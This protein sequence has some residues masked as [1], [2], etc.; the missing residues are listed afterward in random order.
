MNSA[1]A[2]EVLVRVGDEVLRDRP[3]VANRTE[4]FEEARVEELLDRYRFTAGQLHIA[5]LNPPSHFWRDLRASERLR[6]CVLQG[7]RELF[8]PADFFMES[9]CAEDCLF[10]SCDTLIRSPSV[11]LIR[12]SWLWLTCVISALDERD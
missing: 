2:L 7:R 10:F 3:L 9:P 1:L 4:E 5:S 11:E 6:D 8:A 12:L